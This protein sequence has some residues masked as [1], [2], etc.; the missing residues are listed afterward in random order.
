MVCYLA[1]ENAVPVVLTS[2]HF[3]RYPKLVETY[4]LQQPKSSP[5]NESVSSTP[6]TS[7]DSQTEQQVRLQYRSLEVSV[8]AQEG[9]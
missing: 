5:R 3:A 6:E 1:Q 2:A 8:E 4:A 7:G 9:R